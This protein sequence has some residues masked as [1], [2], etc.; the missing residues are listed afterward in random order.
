MTEFAIFETQATK[1]MDTLFDDP[2]TRSNLTKIERAFLKIASDD[3][4]LAEF[5]H[6]DF[7]ARDFTHYA[8]IC[9][10]DTAE[11]SFLNLYCEIHR[12]GSGYSSLERKKLDHKQGYF[13]HPGG[14]SPLLKAQSHI[15]EDSVVADLGAGNGLQGL[16][17]Q[18]LYPHRKTV[19]IELS[20][21]MIRIGKMFQKA[22]EIPEEKVDWIN[23]DILNV[24]LDQIDFLYLY[25]PSKPMQNGL[26]LYEN[27][28]QKLNNRDKSLTIFSI[29]DCLKGYLSS[30]YKEF[31]NDGHLTCFNLTK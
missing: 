29:A 7:V 17:F 22:L 20:A 31:Y 19:Q 16:L 12:A 13:N 14:I 3:A 1:V 8:Q 27:L 6:I 11:F 23:D 30:D 28:R 21:E 24:S 4:I 26:A 5:P 2:A 15:G 18:T 9:Y 25:R 10:D